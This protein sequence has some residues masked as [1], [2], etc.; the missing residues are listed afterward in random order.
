MKIRTV[1]EIIGNIFTV[2]VSTEEWSENDN[3]SMASYGE[4]EIDL[5]G[6][7]TGPPA[8]SLPSTFSRI[9]SGSPFIGKFDGDDEAEAEDFADVWA[10]EIIARLK[11]EITTLRALSDEFTGETVET[12]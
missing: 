2:Q 9:K 5:G 11:A 4:P 12:Y 7:F 3:E 6:D 10:T 8:F 1:K